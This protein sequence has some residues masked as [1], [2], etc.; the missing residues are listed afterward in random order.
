MAALRPLSSCSMPG[1]DAGLGTVLLL[2]CTE[3]AIVP[4]DS[5]LE[6]GCFT[7]SE[8]AALAALRQASTWAPPDTPGN[9]W[10]GAW[11]LHCAPNPILKQGS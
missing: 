5:L 9:L 4:L 6:T 3:Y 7:R 8:T 1:P 10:V 11:H 2:L